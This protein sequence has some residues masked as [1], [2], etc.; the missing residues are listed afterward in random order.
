MRPL[1][2]TL[3][4]FGPYAGVTDIPFEKLGDRG[5]YLITGDTGSG[6]TFLFDAIVFALYGEASGSARET[7]MF[8]SKYADDDAETYVALRFAHREAVYEVTRRPEYLRPARRGSGMT[9]SRAEATLVY[10]D[11]HVVTKSRDVTAAVTELLGIDRSRFTQIAMIAQGDFLRLLYAR[12]EERSGIFREIFHTRAYAVLQEKLKAESG[13]LRQQ[14]EELDKRIEQ[15]RDG[16][17]WEEERTVS[18]ETLHTTEELLRELDDTLAWQSERMEELLRELREIDVSLEQ[19]SQMIGMA[20]TEQAMREEADRAAQEAARIEPDIAPLRARLE[21]LRGEKE[22]YETMRRRLHSEEEKL[23][24]YEETEKLSGEADRI[25]EEAELLQKTHDAKAA[26]TERLREAL[27]RGAERIDALQDAEVQILRLTQQTEQSRKRIAV[28]G[29]LLGLSGEV[30]RLAQ[31]LLDRQ[32]QY[33]AASA[34]QRE[35]KAAY[36]RLQQRYLDEQ[37][38][39]LAGQLREGEPCPVCG[40]LTHPQPAGSCEDAPDRETVRKARALWEQADFAMRDASTQAGRAKG[41]LDNMAQTLQNRLSAE[42]IDGGDEERTEELLQNSLEQEKNA[43]DKL[44]RELQEAE[45]RRDERE[46]LAARQ[47]KLESDLC[48]AEQ[49]CKETEE[50]IA[51]LRTRTQIL[52]DRISEKQ[53]SLSHETKAGAEKSIAEKR[54]ALAAYEQAVRLAEESC[55]ETENA[56][57]SAVQR[58]ETLRGQLAQDGQAACLEELLKK[59]EKL[60]EHRRQ[61]Q[62]AQQRIAYRYE[63]DRKLRDAIAGQSEALSAAQ[64]R[65]GMVRELSNTVNG[66]LTGKD[67]IMLETYVQMH[68]FD[69]ILRRANTRFMVMSA[70]QYELKRSAQADSLKRQSG[71]ELDVTD[72]YNGTQ[73]SVRTLSGGEAFLASLSLALGLSDEIQSVSGGIT[74]ETMFVDEGFGSLDEAALHQAL[75]ALAGLTEG[76]RL[77]GIIS[78]VS[79]LKERID[80]QVIVT[81]DAL[82]GSSVC[83]VTQ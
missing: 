4:A 71:L 48:E 62:E 41:A 81:K 6:K 59:Q 32:E 31:E 67:K 5:L 52:A 68:Y 47:K 38:G 36:E 34:R 72:H 3:S 33:R 42:G 11:G 76:N 57:Q 55:T 77:V 23:P 16:I 53:G 24:A 60:S 37:A 64:E 21:E 2:L 27:A 20:R 51:R 7:S 22:R 17:L 12:T 65:W 39:V 29:E 80:R 79:E 46:K 58:R 66:N 70:G 56:Y 18:P 10:P 50:E 82:T 26:E 19:N 25:R 54:E 75:H 83:L 78:H 1:T 61:R 15:Y 40:S 14:C 13:A 45:Q 28:W 8:R 74:L 63:T 49:R 43:A 44:G 73:R 69:R 35:E 9:V 30:K